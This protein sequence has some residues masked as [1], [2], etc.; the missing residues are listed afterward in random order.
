MRA[1]GHVCVRLMVAIVAVSTSGNSFGQQATREI[2]SP[3]PP[4]K[5]MEIESQFLDT[6][7][8]V[9]P[10]KLTGYL[11]SAR[12]LKTSK[13]AVI[14]NEEKSREKAVHF[15]QQ[16]RK[17]WGLSKA[18]YESLKVT[19][20]LSED[21]KR[22]TVVFKSDKP[23]PYPGYEDIKGFSYTPHLHAIVT[24]S[25]VTRVLN[26][27]SKLPRLKHLNKH[28]SHPD[29][30]ALVQDQVIGR[31]LTYHD[32]AGRRVSVGRIDAG[33]ILGV[34]RVVHVG[35][36]PESRD[37]KVARLAWRFEIEIKHLRWFIFVDAHTAELIAV[38][39]G[40]QT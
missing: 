15:V 17:Y 14:R 29:D 8:S 28:P 27:T 33:H 20:K 9:T 16:N 32:K 24:T 36:N 1:I 18:E 38:Q 4:L 37:E 35:P 7:W 23:F 11:R 40:F 31:E 30:A 21:R 12:R 2:L 5:I 39:Q 22:L 6:G 3:L 13:P 26:K 19:A 10:Q 34:E 25:G